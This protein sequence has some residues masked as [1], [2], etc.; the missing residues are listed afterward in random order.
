[1]QPV[2]STH[3]ALVPFQELDPETR[4]FDAPYAQAIRI[5]AHWANSDIG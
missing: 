5:A 2:D 4:S 1:M 3:K